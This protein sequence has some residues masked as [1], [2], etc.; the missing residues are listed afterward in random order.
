MD[1]GSAARVRRANVG[2]VRAG[3][4]L[5]RRRWRRRITRSSGVYVFLGGGRR[6]PLG[7]AHDTYG[8]R[9]RRVRAHR[10]L[11]RRRRRTTVITRR[12]N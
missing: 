1:A 4:A 5:P 2:P 9:P 6:G 8:R 10:A 3:V 12:K 11:R 7:A